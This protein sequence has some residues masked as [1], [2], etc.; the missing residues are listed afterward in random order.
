MD[1]IPHEV[2]AAYWS[3]SEVSTNLIIFMNLV[4]ALSPGLASSV[5]GSSCARAS[6]SAV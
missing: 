2:L 5:P 3:A 6:I 4:G 1:P